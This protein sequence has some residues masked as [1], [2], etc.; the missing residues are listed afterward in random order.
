MAD[1]YRIPLTPT[2]QR[3]TI[4]LDGVDYIIHL[5]YR[6]VDEGGWT[7]DIHDIDD[8]P[9]VNGIP[10]VTGTNLLG[11]YRHLGFTGG[12]WVQT[13]SDPDAVPTFVNLGVDA[14]LYWVSNGR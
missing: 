9:I 1:Y 3:F 5:N 11:Q 12:L 14:F 4:G 8:N 10:L 13:A 2:P 6:N 7:I